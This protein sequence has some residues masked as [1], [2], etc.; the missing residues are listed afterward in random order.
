MN[1]LRSRGTILASVAAIGFYGVFIARTRFSADGVVGFTLFD[2]AM[3]SMRYARNLVEGHGLVFNP[4]EPVEGYSNPLWTLWMALV[5]AIGPGDMFA[6]L[7]VALTGVLLL[8]ASGYVAHRLAHL[9][10]GHLAA[11]DLALTFL[12]FNYAYLFWTLR[13]MEV[14]ALGLLLI[15][16]AL[17]AIRF[18]E[19]ADRTHL[20]GVAIALAAAILTRRDAVVGAGVIA[21]Y[22]GRALTGRDRVAAVVATLVAT[23]T[24]FAAQSAFS[25]WYYG[26]LLPNTYYLKMT[27]APVLE[28][29]QHG[30]SAGVLTMF[31][32]VGPLLVPAVVPL[33]VGL[34]RQRQAAGLLLALVAAQLTYSM[35]VGGD[36]WEYNGYANRFIATALPGLC[37]LAA[38]GAC[39]AV[40]AGRGPLLLSCVLA[41]AGSRVLIELASVTWNWLPSRGSGIY[42]AAPVIVSML[43]GVL[44]L[45]LFI[46]AAWLGRA[47]AGLGSHRAATAGFIL[48]LVWFTANG[49]AFIAWGMAN[50]DHV[51]LDA[52][53]ASAG[54]ALRRQTSSR[55]VLAVTAAGNLPYFSRLR[56][57]D[58]HGKM[59]PV[60]AHSPAVGV[61][62]PGHDKWNLAHSLAALPDVIATFGPTPDESTFLRTL[63][64]EPAPDGSFL[65]RGSPRLAAGGVE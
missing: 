47:R 33:F 58:L 38:V 5:H 15:V 42:G 14:G 7:I 4:G 55:A 63:G 57:I 34:R 2:D 31:R 44:A 59:D 39:Q 8:L 28:R 62:R 10:W 50:A 65:L 48:A 1:T 36:A 16:A 53:W 19:T 37:V 22:L 26:A 12:L 3:I 61:F 41:A 35:Y 6:P 11:A 54:V 21:A 51:E 24:A 64:Y 56:T 46:T 13:G 52:R 29:L 27:G 49:P 45:T 25:F 43:A 17:F 40:T 9:T 30:A 20:V 23:S 32:N 18:V 60:I